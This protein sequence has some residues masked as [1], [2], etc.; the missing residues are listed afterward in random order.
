MGCK[1]KEGEQEGHIFRKE[2]V[3]NLCSMFYM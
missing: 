1:I 2:N 3:K